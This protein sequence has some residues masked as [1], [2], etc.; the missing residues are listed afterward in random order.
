VARVA[1]NRDEK[2]ITFQNSGN[3]TSKFIEIEVC[4]DACQPRED[5]YLYPGEEYFLTVSKDASLTLTQVVGANRRTGT[6]PK[7]AQ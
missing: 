6:I 2:G 1:W 4:E 3:I 5:I 7:F